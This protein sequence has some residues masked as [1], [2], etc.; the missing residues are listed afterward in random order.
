MH[1][2][3]PLNKLKNA[4]ELE[5]LIKSKLSRVNAIIVIL[6]IA[7]VFPKELDEDQFLLTLRKIRH[8]RS[9]FP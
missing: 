6:R 1:A 5:L 3:M 9:P 2:G 7:I 4:L 8:A